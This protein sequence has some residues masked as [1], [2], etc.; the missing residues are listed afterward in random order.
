MVI[1]NSQTG[2][3]QD[4]FQNFNSC[5]ENIEHESPTNERQKIAL[6]AKTHKKLHKISTRNVHQTTFKATESPNIN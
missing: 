3:K 1:S 5:Q 4:I 2:E 6:K